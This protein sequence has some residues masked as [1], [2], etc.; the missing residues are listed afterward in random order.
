MKKII[1]SQLLIIFSLAVIAQVHVI[2]QESFSFNPSDIEVNVGDTIRWEW[3]GGTHTTTSLEIPEGAAAWDSPLNSTTQ[4]FEYK[5]LTEGVYNYK[6]TPHQAM[7]MI[8]SFTALL[9]LISNNISSSSF[10]I[11]PNPAND[12]IFIETETSEL[13]TMTIFNW[14]GQILMEYKI[15]D[16]QTIDISDLSSGIYFY[17]IKNSDQTYVTANKIIKE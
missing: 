4:F 14:S 17:Q 11:Y 10:S 15:N 16:N 9:P 6:C 7:G 3:T 2:R 12:L 8:G 1:L 13:F 5:V